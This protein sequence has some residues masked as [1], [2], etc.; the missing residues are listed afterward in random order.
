MERN[1]SRQ[2]ENYRDLVRTEASDHAKY[3]YKRLI[4]AA[5]AKME[6][7]SRITRTSIHWNK[8]IYRLKLVR[9]PFFSLSL[10]LLLIV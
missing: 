4:N 7:W 6:I 5:G 2:D 9:V 3:P 1:D 10:S 8:V